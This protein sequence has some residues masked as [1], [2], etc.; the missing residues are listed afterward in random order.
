MGTYKDPS[1]RVGT[2]T[3][4]A[5]LFLLFIAFARPCLQAGDSTNSRAVLWGPTTNGCQL[6]VEFAQTNFV[7]DE[8][9]TCTVHLR[10]LGDKVVGY[11]GTKSPHDPEISLNSSPSNRSNLTPSIGSYRQRPG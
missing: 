6:G 4:K 3:I 2:A 11:T 9:V 8:P 5:V 7:T 1:P 10:N